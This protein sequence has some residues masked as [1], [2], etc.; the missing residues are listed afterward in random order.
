MAIVARIDIFSHNFKVSK[1]QREFYQLL[2]E[3]CRPLIQTGLEPRPGGRFVP[4]MLKTFAAANATR[5]ELRF[6]ISKYRDFL[7]WCKHRGYHED[8]FEVVHHPLFTPAPLKS[9]F[10]ESWVLRPHQVPIVDFCAEEGKKIRALVVQPGVGKGLM[11]LKT[12]ERLGHRVIVIVPAM[13]T[14][15]WYEEIETMFAAVSKR[16]LMVKGFKQLCNLVALAKAGNLDHDFIIVSQTSMQIFI[17][18]WEHDPKLIEEM[19]CHPE[20]FYEIIGAGTKIIDELHKGIHVNIKMDLYTNIL[21]SLYLTATI[22]A[23]NPFIN[24]MNEMAYPVEDRYQGLAYDRYIGVIAMEYRLQN[25]KAARWVGRKKE[26]S[27]T[28]YEGS[29]LR[30]PKMRENYSKMV[31]FLVQDTFIDIMEKGQTC[32]VFAGSIDMCTHL[33]K[34]L[35]KKYPQ[36][37]IGRYVGE[38]DYEELMKNDIVV[39]TI[40]SAGTAIDKYGLVTVIMTQ[41]VDSIQANEQT[42]GRLRRLKDWPDTTPKFY[43]LVCADIDKHIT[44]HKR[45]VELL[46]EKALWQRYE[47]LP[48]S[49]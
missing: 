24:R 21:K 27:Q 36:F 44:Y 46:K 4:V 7:G 9:K 6:C 40:L 3:Y 42:M 49:I 37:K 47:L 19:C 17:R 34:C 48:F 30:S 28:L 12:A 43:Y 1:Y 26:Y 31:E 33:A 23:S 18:D 2:K 20:E 10:I 5:T 22:K 15:K 32:L 45:K 14:E 16:M 39:S 29:I 13:Y 25:P 38:D 41:A 35:K 8:R 11:S